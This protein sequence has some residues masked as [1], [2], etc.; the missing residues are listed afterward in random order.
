MDANP[1]NLLR[2]LGSS[3]R[4]WAAADKYEVH[5]EWWIALTGESNASMNL[6]CCQSSDATILRG[7]C[8]EPILNLGKPGM[9]MLGGAGLGAAQTLIDEGWANVGALPLMLLTTP[10][11]ERTVSTDVRPISIDDL[12]SAREI[13]VDTFSLSA[14]TVGTVLPDSLTGRHDIEVWG[15]FEA[16]RMISTVTNV[17]EDDVA[18]V[19]MMATRRESQGQGHGRRL[20]EVVLHEQFKNGVV[21][22]LLHSS[23]AGERLYRG[24]GY[25][26]VEYLQLWSRPRW[27][28]GSA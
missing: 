3:T 11:A 16:D 13:L 18:V 7:N 2:V 12:T 9:I 5:P 14:S 21:G 25:Q 20:L 6:A 4:V 10:P 23:K 8:L 17:R 26:D 15:L 1:A 27:V 22:S 24:V 19:W 28:L